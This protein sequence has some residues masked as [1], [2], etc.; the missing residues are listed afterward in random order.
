MSASERTSRKP[1]CLTQH[2]HYRS[3]SSCVVPVPPHLRRSVFE[4]FVSRCG[5]AATLPL[6]R[7]D[8]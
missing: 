2:E 8:R 4:D 1:A 3:I 6:P 5:L 7:C